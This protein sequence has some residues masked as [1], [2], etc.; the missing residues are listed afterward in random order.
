MDKPL[1]VGIKGNNIRLGAF[2]GHA[3]GKIGCF[4]KKLEHHLK[5]FES[6]F[7]HINYGWM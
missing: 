6:M 4:S 5:A 1:T 3:F 2:A 7:H